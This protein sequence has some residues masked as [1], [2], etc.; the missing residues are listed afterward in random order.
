[1]ILNKA[2]KQ[3]ITSKF[4]HLNDKEK[5]NYCFKFKDIDITSIPSHEPFFSFLK[6]H[7]TGYGLVY[8]VYG[9]L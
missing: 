1:M 3:L 6:E 4:W 7:W 8:S 9:L 5:A 2:P